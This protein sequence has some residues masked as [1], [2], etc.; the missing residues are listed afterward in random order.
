MANEISMS[1]ALSASLGGVTVGAS[2]SVQATM[3]DYADTLLHAVQ[4]VGYSVAE[5]VNLGDVNVAREYLV[6]LT[7]LDATNF[8]DVIPCDGGSTYR[9]RMRPG[10]SFGPVRVIGGLGSGKVIQVKADTAAC[11]VEVV[12]VEA[13]PSEA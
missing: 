11:R 1:S 2:R 6:H 10:E 9:F 8:V 7:N 5:D 3:G 4:D 12:V 13:D